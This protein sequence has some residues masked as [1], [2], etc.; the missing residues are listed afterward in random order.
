M[1]DREELQY[2]RDELG[3]DRLIKDILDLAGQVGQIYND[4]YLIRKGIRRLEYD[5]EAIQAELTLQAAE[6]GKNESQRKA[7]LSQKMREHPQLRQM[8]EQKMK[9]EM[10]LEE[11]RA[12][13]QMAETALNARRSVCYLIGQV[14]A[15]V[16]AQAVYSLEGYDEGE[17]DRT[18]MDLRDRD[19]GDVPF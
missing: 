12:Q 17:T 9:L 19:S 5:M 7:I 14:L 16:H 4:E 3:I 10:E 13:R 18:S 2:I 15:A 8:I 11:K 6:E 1:I